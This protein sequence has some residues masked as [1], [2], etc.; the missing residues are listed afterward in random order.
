MPRNINRRVE[1]LFPVKDPRIIRYLHDE[2]LTIYLNDNV[3]ARRMLSNGSYE[4]VK[5]GKDGPPLNSQLW[6]LTRH[7]RIEKG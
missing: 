6:L 4:R 1:V 7:Q 5:P 2:V 3:K